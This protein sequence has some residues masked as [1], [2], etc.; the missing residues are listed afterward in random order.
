MKISNYILLGFLIIIVLF[1]ITT[2]INFRLANA[3]D[4]HAEYLARSAQVI[5]NSARYQRNVLAIMNGVRSYLFTREPSYF[6]N[7]DSGVAENDAI[8]QQL[9]A[10]TRDQRQKGFLEAIKEL[11]NQ[12]A[13]N[14]VTPVRTARLRL[15]TN[16]TSAITF[17]TLYN[18]VFSGTADQD[19]LNFLQLRIRDFTNREYELRDVQNQ[20]LVSSVRRTRQISIVLTVLSVLVASMVMTFL[21]RRISQRIAKMVKIAN[22]IASGNYGVQMKDPGSDELSAL[23]FS[24]NHM[25]QELSNNIALLRTKNQELDQFAHIVSHDLKG[26]LRGIDNVVTWIEEDHKAELAPK[27]NEY[28]GIIKGRVS[29]AQNLIDGILSYARTDKELRDKELVDTKLLVEDIV[30]GVTANSKIKVEIGD[31]PTIT[32]ERIPFF[33]VM[34]NLVDNAIKYNDNDH[35]V[36]RIYC[37]ETSSSYEFFIADNGPGIAEI[38]HKK[39]FVIFQT[40]NERDSFE[41]TGVGLAIVRKILDARNEKI[42]VNSE[43]GKGSIF[44]FTWAKSPL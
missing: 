17:T 24:L 20:R 39:I 6:E 44:A 41:S 10:T 12:L 25:S 11:N 32:T 19:L 42:T 37:K 2:F 16:D 9:A 34:S 43:V 35:P 38:Y 1:S 7:T 28:L 33:Q 14:Y 3:V 22:S 31:L 4:V 5:R 26:P 27:L 18:D 23:A 40:L 8:L 30:Q 21:I 36:V 29:R 13:N 15:N